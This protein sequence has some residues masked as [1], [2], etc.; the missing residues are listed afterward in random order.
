[1][2]FQKNSTSSNGSV[3]SNGGMFSGTSLEPSMNSSMTSTIT[4]FDDDNDNILPTTTAVITF[5]RNVSN[6]TTT[7][8]SHMPSKPL[9]GPLLSSCGVTR[10]GNRK[11]HKKNKVHKYLARWPASDACQSS[12]VGAHDDKVNPSH[13]QMLLDQSTFALERVMMKEPYDRTTQALSS[14]HFVRET[15]EVQINLSKGTEMIPLGVATMVV[16]GDEEGP[17]IMSVPAK[18]VVYKGKKKVVRDDHKRRDKQSKNSTATHTSSASKTNASSV[19]HQHATTA[20]STPLSAARLFQKSS[21]KMAFPSDPTRRYTLDDNASLK[22]ALQVIP[23]EALKETAAAKAR[24]KNDTSGRRRMYGNQGSDEENS[25][26]AARKHMFL[27]DSPRNGT[28]GGCCAM[29]VHTDDDFH[30]HLDDDYANERDHVH[31]GQGIQAAQYTTV[32]SPRSPTVGS[33]LFC[34]GLCGSGDGSATTHGTDNNTS[35]AQHD[36]FGGSSPVPHTRKVFRNGPRDHVPD[37]ET[38]LGPSS[39]SG[40]FS[41]LGDS[42]VLSSVSES[43]SGSSDE[44]EDDE[45]DDY[46]DDGDL[47]EYGEEEEEDDDDDY[48]EYTSR[49]DRLLHRK[50]I[51]RNHEGR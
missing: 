37:D 30:H 44:D 28:G 13:D 45:E 16:N 11:H 23:N 4:S 29:R 25:I 34:G 7:I 15:I 43:D 41:G 39:N 5:R 2:M 17:I 48:E 18:A 8:A 33:G 21:R 22:I 36:G 12:F 3:L 6:S 9:G 14:S 49:R 47:D 27:L 51:V 10:S 46:F 35:M 32:I 26:L 1:M 50:I 42:F 31:H 19:H 38:Y 20:C 24:R 40:R